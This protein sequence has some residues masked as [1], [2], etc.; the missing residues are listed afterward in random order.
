MA[1][2]QGI[3]KAGRDYD[4][5]KRPSLEPYIEWAD[6]MMADLDACLIDREESYT[7]AKLEMI[8]R[9]LAAHAYAMSDQTY[10]NK[11]TGGASGTFHGQT[12]KYLEATK[13]GQMALQLDTAGCLARGTPTTA[14]A[15][16]GGKDTQDQLDY[17]ERN[18]E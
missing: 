12:G 17:D 18:T 9:Y 16:W 4:V 6:V 7:D 14:E 3:L 13:Y 5:R 8:A 11:S 15:W 10:A 2:V 1:A